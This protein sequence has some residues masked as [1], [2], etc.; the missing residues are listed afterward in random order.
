MADVTNELL[1][2][3]TP[4]GCDLRDL[5]GFMLNT[6][7]LLAS[8]LWALAT[9]DEFRAAVALWCRAWKQVPAASLPNDFT[10]IAA[11][12]GETRPWFMKHKDIVLRGFILCSDG[13]LYHR[14]L[15]EDATRAWEKKLRR[16]TERNADAER[17]KQWRERR[18]NGD[19]TPTKR[20]R[21]GQGQGQGQKK[22]KE[23]PLPPKGDIVLPD[24]LPAD[25]WADFVAHRVKLKK[26]MTDGAIK[27]V[28]AKL[29]GFR[30][31]GLDPGAL[32]ILAMERGW[33]TVFAPSPAEL[34][35]CR[36]KTAKPHIT[37]IMSGWA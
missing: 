1:Q 4:V 6:E 23:S 17:L 12:A 33:L 26:P 7:R 15:S 11:F 20:V 8:E 14:T 10:T 22:E 2:P 32:L 35:R 24:W 19:E 13:R 29:D 3:L 31:N 9:G 36:A 18:K 28:I 34:P 30:G 5:P 27:A 21:Q 37:E 16:S 25:T